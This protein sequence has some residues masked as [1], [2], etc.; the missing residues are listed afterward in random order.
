LGSFWVYLCESGRHQ[1]F[2]CEAVKEEGE[3][4]N[5]LVA[6]ALG[7]V[8]CLYIWV[9]LRP[10]AMNVGFSW[11]FIGIVYAAILTKGFKKP[12]RSIDFRETE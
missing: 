6:P 4:L 10:I 12:P 9:S 5:Y 2:P 11:L 7:F 8:F 3:F 1:P